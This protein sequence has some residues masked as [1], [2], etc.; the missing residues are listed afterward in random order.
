MQG[1]KIITIHDI[2]HQ[3]KKSAG[4]AKTMWIKTKYVS[5]N[6]DHFSISCEVTTG[7]HIILAYILN[8]CQRI[9]CDMASELIKIQ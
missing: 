7:P 9:F 8:S 3:M 5:Y 2:N 6:G 1:Q 4:K